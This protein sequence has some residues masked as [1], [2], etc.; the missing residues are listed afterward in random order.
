MSTNNKTNRRLFI[1]LILN[2]KNQNYNTVRC[3]FP[4]FYKKKLYL[5]MGVTDALKVG[6]IFPVGLMFPGLAKLSIYI[7]ELLNTVF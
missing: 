1:F 4:L 2:L 3:V 6:V 7:F 5:G